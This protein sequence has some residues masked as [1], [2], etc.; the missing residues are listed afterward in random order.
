MRFIILKY[1]WDTLPIKG[2][3]IEVNRKR[4]RNHYKIV[5]PLVGSDYPIITLENQILGK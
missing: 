4:A 5:N 3:K 2:E 1:Y